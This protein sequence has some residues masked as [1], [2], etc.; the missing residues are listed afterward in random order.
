MTRFRSHAEEIDAAVAAAQGAVIDLDAARRARAEAEARALRATLT[1]R[2]RE[3][4]ALLAHIVEV[5]R[6]AQDGGWHEDFDGDNGG[7]SGRAAGIALLWLIALLLAAGLWLLWG[8]LA[9]DAE[10]QPAPCAPRDAVLGQLAQRFGESRQAFGLRGETQL[11]ELFAS[12][13]T[14]T[15]TITSTDTAGV[16]CIIGSGQDFRLVAEAPGIP[17]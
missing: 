6:A 1:D 5:V 8:V 13:E 14:G 2:Q 11:V 15:W 17:G 12:I 9:G 3:K 10:A 16:T 4:E 7:F